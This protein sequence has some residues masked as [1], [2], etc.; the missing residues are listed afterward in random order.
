MLSIIVPTY[1]EA[2]NIPVLAERLH[3]VLSSA[4]ID[5]ELIISDDNSPDSTKQVVEELTGR[6]PIRL[7]QPKGRE[8][9]LSLSVIDGIK[10]A[11][12]DLVVVM[13]ADLSHPPEMVPQMLQELQQESDVFCRGKPLCPRW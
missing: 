13:D 4:G 7:L 5:Y 8:K 12:N 11:T 3:D 10:A 6:L 9:D 1:C 2:D